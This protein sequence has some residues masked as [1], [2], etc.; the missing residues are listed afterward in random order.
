MDSLAF[1]PP[2]LEP[3]LF[4]HTSPVVPRVRLVVKPPQPTVEEDDT[5][6]LVEGVAETMR[7]GQ[8]YRSIGFEAE[9]AIVGRA[10]AERSKYIPDPLQTISDCHVVLGANIEHRRI[11]TGEAQIAIAN[12]LL[13]GLHGGQ[14]DAC[15][16]P[17]MAPSEDPESYSAVCNLSIS[18]L[19]HSE[20][21]PSPVVY[22]LQGLRST[23]ASVCWVPGWNMCQD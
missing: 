14:L 23:S 19:T 21:L 20:S 22:S 15:E 2:D 1:I 9:R 5:S 10:L 17:Y 3:S 12:A 16:P 11:L 8:S 4:H 13:N 6:C 18:M 7:L